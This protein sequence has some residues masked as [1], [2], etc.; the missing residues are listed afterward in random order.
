MADGTDNRTALQIRINELQAENELLKKLLDRAGIPYEHEL[1]KLKQPQGVEPYDEN[2]GGRIRRPNEI[3][4]DMAKKFLSFFR[5]RPD[6]FAR[7]SVK[8]NTGEAGYY[9]QCVNFWT[10]VCARKNRSSLLCKEC[11]FRKLAPLQIQDIRNHLLGHSENGTDVIG[12]YPLM[13]DNTSQLLVFDF[14]YHGKDAQKDDF[15][16]KNDD[17]REEV[18]AMRTICKLNGIDALVERSR[19]GKGAH[20]WIFF[21]KPI[22]ASLIRSFGIALLEKGAQQVNLTS[23]RYYDRMLPAQDSLKN[24]EYGN[25]IALPLQGKALNDGNSAFIDENWNAYQ[26]QW[27]TLLGK[28]K[29][30]EEFIQ[31]KMKEWADV[32]QSSDGMEKS[33]DHPWDNSDF[34]SSDVSGTM[35]ITL[36]DGI[37]INKKNLCPAIQNRIR[38]LAAF[39]NP[40]YFKNIGLGKSNFDTPSWIYLGEDHPEGYLEIPRGCY[41]GLIR[42]NEKAGIEYTVHDERQYGRPIRVSFNGS[43]YDYQKDGLQEMMKHENGIMQATTAYGKTV[44]CNAM[45]AARK[46]NTLIILEKQDLIPQWKESFEK[47][48]TIDEEPPF[49]ETKTKKKKRRKSVIGILHGSTDTTTGIIDIAMVGSICKKDVFHEKLNQYGMVIVDECH[50]SASSTMQNVL[51]EVKARY[52]YGVTATPNRAD[53][54]QKINYMLLG[55]LRYKYTAKQRAKAQGIGHYVYP[56][57]TRTVSPRGVFKD[58]MNAN[59]HYEILRNNPI[60]DRQIL[61][62]IKECVIKGRTSVVLSKYTD[63]ITRLYEAAGEYADHVYLLVGKNSAKENEAMIRKM[64]G[65]PSDES[66]ILFA[67]GSLIG[68]GFDFPRLDTLFMATP[69]SAENIVEQYA[70]RLHRDYEGKED[71][72]IYDYVDTYIPMFDK[73]Y[74]KRLKTYKKIGYEIYS[75]M[76][77]EPTEK[78]AIF[79]VD[80]YC[81][82]FKDDLVHAQST[83]VIS[84]TEIT[85]KKINHLMNE[86]EQLQ[87]KGVTVTVVTWDPDHEAFGDSTS[88]M[89]ILDGIRQSAILLKTME[90]HCE[91]FAIIDQTT[92][93]YGNIMLL[94]R[95]LVDTTM[96]RVESREIAAELMEV[97]FGEKQK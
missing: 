21:E 48:L 73:M 14:D 52:V 29:L 63:H 59:E 93:W 91:N 60:R 3:T 92:V 5:G 64:K 88:R 44:V 25:L 43:L 4:D 12:I 8:K 95:D 40:T 45:I 37:Y 86:I 83:V 71:V 54:M 27:R 2:Q 80:T 81:P 72:I 23:F 90:E 84:S 74:A 51:K 82:A 20:I 10:D 39:H 26:Y 34:V 16:N 69:V 77:E 55:P 36:A 87:H 47:F 49:Y 53:Q 67:T 35:E 28:K 11:E 96:M 85:K 70:G 6:V 9:P 42:S 7:R 13:R 22:K 1:K 19:S 24:L 31:Q 56:R 18:E 38:H 76:V 32:S 46:V 57:F 66:V 79:D 68:E 33:D 17:W 15:A 75:E 97:T 50:H 94:G 30:S 78:N 61:S 65:L 62:D 89:A 58:R 41:G